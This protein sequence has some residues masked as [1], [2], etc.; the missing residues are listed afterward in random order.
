MWYFFNYLIFIALRDWER[1][2]HVIH[3]YIKGKSK[4]FCLIVLVPFQSISHD[5]FTNVTRLE[6]AEM[7][8]K[9]H[10]YTLDGVTQ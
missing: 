7:E 5:M 6:A 10:Y 3:Q 9:Y 8:D 2:S 4:W 1:N